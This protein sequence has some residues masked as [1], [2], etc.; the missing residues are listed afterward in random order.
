MSGTQSDYYSVIVRAVAALDAN[1]PDSRQALYNRARTVQA[2]KL[3][4]FEPPLSR[5]KVEL[6]CEALEQAIRNLRSAIGSRMRG[7]GGQKHDAP[8]CPFYR[9]QPS[10]RHPC[11]R[12]VP[13]SRPFDKALAE[14]N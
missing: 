4:G 2:T 12:F 10:P 9:R 5:E 6:E 1:T 8:P 14:L 7:V 3:N 11:R 13:G